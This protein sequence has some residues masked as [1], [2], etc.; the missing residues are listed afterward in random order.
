MEEVEEVDEVEEVEEVDEEDEVEDHFVSQ[1]EQKRLRKE[2]KKAARMEKAE[3]TPIV[4]PEYISVANLAGMLRLR[5]EDFVTKLEE[6]GFE[7]VQATQVLNAEHAGLI[8]QEYNFEP[9]FRG[10]HE[11]GDLYAA[12]APTEEEYAELPA[13]PPVVT[14]MGHVDHGKT[15]ILDYMRSTSQWQEDHVSGH[16]WSLGFR[17]HAC[18]WCKRHR[19]C[20]SRRFSR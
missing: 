2:A 7:D 9:T 6:L 11:D 10:E 14:I 19:H 16:T 13:R 17:D 4:L 12:P 15:T 3:P 8:A 1:K 5:V 20:G 18:S